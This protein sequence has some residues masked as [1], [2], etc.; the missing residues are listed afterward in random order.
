[1][2][3]VRKGSLSLG[4]GVLV[5][6]ALAP[7]ASPTLPGQSGLI[8]FVSYPVGTRLGNGI[9]VMRADGSRMRML[10]AGRHDRSPAWS[11]KGR[12]VVFERGARLYVVGADGRG[13]RRLTPRTLGYH[14][15]AWSPDGHSIAFDRGGSIFLMTANGKAE[16]LIYRATNPPR[17]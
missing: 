8:A 11:P 2:R 12:W 4:L 5:A 6:L 9:A 1:M 13:L 14:G 7:L 10:T 17:T 16:H 3:P 15:P